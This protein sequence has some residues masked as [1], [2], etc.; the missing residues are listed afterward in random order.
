ME[1]KKTTEKLEEYA[2][3]RMETCSKLF[4]SL[5]QAELNLL[6]MA[7][8]EEKHIKQLVKQKDSDKETF[9]I[10][11]GALEEMYAP[12]ADPATTST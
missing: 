6:V 9:F 3:E 11:C 5:P 1:K 7:G 2:K 12:I 10:L 4:P 8:F